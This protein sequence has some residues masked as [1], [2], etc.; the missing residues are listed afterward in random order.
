MLTTHSALA[1]VRTIVSAV[2]QVVDKAMAHA[3][4][5]TQAGQGIDAHQVHCE[6]LAYRATELRAAQDFLRYVDNAQEHGQEATVMASMALAYAA[7]VGQTLAADLQA[8]A[9]TYGIDDTV[10]HNTLGTAEVWQ[11][12]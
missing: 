12:I 5:L 3:C 9:P 2:Q 10:L 6:R 4:H 8:Q 7:E 1:Q 11:A